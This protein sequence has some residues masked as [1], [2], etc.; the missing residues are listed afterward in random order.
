M[1][2]IRAL[3]K[4]AF[5][6]ASVVCQGHLSLFRSAACEHHDPDEDV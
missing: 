1:H 5:A 2:F 6:F 3:G 4:I